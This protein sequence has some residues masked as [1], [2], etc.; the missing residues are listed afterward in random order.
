VVFAEPQQ[1]SV[2]YKLVITVHFTLNPEQFRLTYSLARS[3]FSKIIEH[4][5]ESAPNLSQLRCDS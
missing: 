5:Q 2:D 3:G 1:G 4:L